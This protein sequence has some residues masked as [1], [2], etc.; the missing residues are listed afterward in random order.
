M[1]IK[2][3]TYI[4]QKNAHRDLHPY[5]SDDHVDV[6]LKKILMTWP[7]CT[8]NRRTMCIH[9]YI[10]TCI[11]ID[12]LACVHEEQKNHAS[13]GPYTAILLGPFEHDLLIIYVRKH[14][15]DII[16]T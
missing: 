2:F 7:A 12:D 16:T 14:N 1:L 11:R 8:R 3:I 5:L 10:H 9:T 6:V 13:E 4:E 15:I